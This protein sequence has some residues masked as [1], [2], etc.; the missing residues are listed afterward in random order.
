MMSGR[1]EI[2]LNAEIGLDA[3]TALGAAGTAG[4]A[5]AAEAVE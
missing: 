4:T 3:E 2:C 5:E 1:A